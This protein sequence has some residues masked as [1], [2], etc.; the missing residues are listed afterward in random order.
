M[1]KKCTR[2]T[3]GK[4]IVTG[5]VLYGIGALGQA[6]AASSP[7]QESPKLELPQMDYDIP[8]LSKIPDMN[9]RHSEKDWISAGA[10]EYEY[11]LV[12]DGKIIYHALLFLGHMYFPC[13]NA[14]DEFIYASEL[15]N[16]E[17]KC[18]NSLQVSTRF[19]RSDD[20]LLRDTDRLFAVYFAGQ[21]C[22][23]WEK[24][25]QVDVCSFKGNGKDWSKPYL[26]GVNIS[27]DDLAE[28][29]LGTF[30]TAFLEKSD[31][32][33]NDDKMTPN[34]GF[35][36]RLPLLDRNHPIDLETLYDQE[37]RT[38]ALR[39]HHT[40]ALNSKCGFYNYSVI[41]QLKDSTVIDH[42]PIMWTYGSLRNL[43]IGVPDVVTTTATVTSK[44]TVTFT[45]TETEN[46]TET[47]T[48]KP[49]QEPKPLFDP[50]SFILGALAGG[51]ATGVGAV[52]VDK[53]L[54]K[55]KKS[56]EDTSTGATE[57]GKGDGK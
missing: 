55:P 5:A 26:C 45:K 13:S 2:R 44:E 8:R 46:V 19:E 56:A 42:S 38:L 16:R 35:K 1:T 29:H 10:K 53:Y 30:G 17:P 15:S 51:V 4:A 14:L 12:E 21:D 32:E 57:A 27:V 28:I 47:K 52:V 40:L 34:A 25:R 3:F 20:P 24:G 41:P 31:A 18:G 22:T 50:G 54:L 6:S 23:V 9:S 37:K 49:P 7:T 33:E 36:L 11:R 48:I 43:S 39:Q